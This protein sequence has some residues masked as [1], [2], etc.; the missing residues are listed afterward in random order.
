MSSDV[1]QGPLSSSWGLCPGLG[2]W[3]LSVQRSK[4][5]YKVTLVLTALT[6]LA[7]HAHCNFHKLKCRLIEVLCTLTEEDLVRQYLC[8]VLEERFLNAV[9]GGVSLF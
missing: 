5:S 2:F 6:L 3:G 7:L 8:A 4:S 9:S 1:I